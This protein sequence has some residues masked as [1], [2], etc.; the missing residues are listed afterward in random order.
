M[1]VCMYVCIYI[2]PP[3]H[4]HRRVERR[5]SKRYCLENPR[6]R[7]AW[8]AAVYGIAQSQT[9][10]S[11]LAAAAAVRG[12]PNIHGQMNELRKCG[13]YTY[14]AI[15]FSLEEYGTTVTCYSI[16]EI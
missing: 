10:L 12:S 11:D 8:W 9:R 2:Y 14:N 16:T 15:L 6:D 4:T 7:G 3:T 13:I 1:Y 5:I